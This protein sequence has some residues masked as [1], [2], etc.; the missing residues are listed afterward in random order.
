MDAADSQE[1][2]L[3]SSLFR[4]SMQTHDVILLERDK[5]SNMP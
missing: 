5:D 3:L 2:F 1:M 4:H